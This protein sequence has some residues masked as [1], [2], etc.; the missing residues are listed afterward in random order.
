MT[1]SDRATVS[2]AVLGGWLACSAAEVRRLAEQG[3]LTCAAQGRFDLKANVQAYTTYL[4]R[5]QAAG[6]HWEGK[7]PY[8]SERLRLTAAKADLAE[9]E[10]QKRAGSLV[11]AAEVKR[12][13]LSI[14]LVVRTGCWRCPPGLRLRLVG[15]T[16]PGD[17]RARQAGGA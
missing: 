12:T 13:W 3:V 11:E 7:G 17:R 4:R 14:L 5:R 8:A 15:K 2:A 16:A 10:R 9:M 1:M 6:S